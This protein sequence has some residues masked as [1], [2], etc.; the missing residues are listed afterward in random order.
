MYRV[1]LE[2]EQGKHT[3]TINQQQLS[4]LHKQCVNESLKHWGFV[5]LQYF[6]K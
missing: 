1:M 6:S 2:P 4:I 5:Q 3:V